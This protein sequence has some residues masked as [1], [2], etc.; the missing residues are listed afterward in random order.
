M[1]NTSN[2]YRLTLSA[3]SYTTSCCWL[4][5]LH[6]I[7][8]VRAFL[9]ICFTNVIIRI[10]P[11]S[12]L[13]TEMQMKQGLEALDAQTKSQK[14]FMREQAS[15]QKS[16]YAMQIDMEVKQQ[17]MLLDQ[18]RQ[19]KVMQLQQGIAM[20]KQQ[21]EQQTMAMMMEYQ[22]KKAEEEMKRNQVE[23]E[24]KQ[25]EMQSKMKKEMD[26]FSTSFSSGF[27]DRQGWSN[28]SSG[29]YY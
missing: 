18:Q 21:M 6:G 3:T 1:H 15:Q 7:F 11:K 19:E 2:F 10:L 5:F 29:Y 8:I 20:Q 9:A 12:Y 16:Q 14:Q 4:L 28:G 25:H 17:E 13:P 26:K 22:Q 27:G 23:M 24:R